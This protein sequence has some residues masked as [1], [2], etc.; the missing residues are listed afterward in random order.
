MNN[1]IKKIID[2]FEIKVTRLSNF[3]GMEIDHDEENGRIF[4]HLRNYI[5]KLIRKFNLEDAVPVSIPADPHVVLKKCEEEDFIENIP[6]REDVGSMM[7]LTIVSR[8]EIMF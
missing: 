1:F 8:P 2:V 4:I 6:Y 3:M 7:F 5:E